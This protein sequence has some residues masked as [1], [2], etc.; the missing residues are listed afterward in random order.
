MADSTLDAKVYLPGTLQLLAPPG[1][2]PHPLPVGAVEAQGGGAIPDGPVEPTPCSQ[3]RDLDV[4]AIAGS[5]A[6][7]GRRAVHFQGGKRPGSPAGG[8][9]SAP[10][11]DG[12]ASGDGGTFAAHLTG[13]KT[14]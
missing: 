12:V 13:V 1:A 2:S 7:A 6:T 14:A 3:P 9:A 10:A 4:G 5:A 11:K 8:K